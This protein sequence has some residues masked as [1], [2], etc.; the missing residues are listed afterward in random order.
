MPRRNELHERINDRFDNMVGNG[1][2][3]EVAAFLKRGIPADKPSMKAIGVPE[4]SRHLAGEISLEQAIADAKTATR[5]YCKRQS[6]WFNNQFD[7]SWQKLETHSVELG[8]A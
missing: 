6:T 2:L 1:A 3:D 4:I 7:D 8:S 5:R